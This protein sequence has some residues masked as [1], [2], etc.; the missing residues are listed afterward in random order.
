MNGSPLASQR[1][2]YRILLIGILL[3]GILPSAC[4]GSFCLTAHFFMSKELCSTDTFTNCPS[5]TL[6]KFFCE[7]C[8]IFTII[9][10]LDHI[11]PGQNRAS[12]HTARARHYKIVDGSFLLSL[13]SLCLQLKHL[14]V[15]SL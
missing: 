4:M 12:E 9:R 14:V 2:P 5:F 15:F 13:M 1:L 10:Q 6:S 11:V 7:I 3:Y 8:Y